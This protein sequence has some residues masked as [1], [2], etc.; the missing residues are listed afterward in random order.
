MA[1]GLVN[2]LFGD[3][4]EAYSAG[5]IPTIVHPYAVQVMAEVG[6]D[7]SQHKAKSVED[8]RDVTFD[9]VVTVCDNA[10]ETCPFFPGAQKYLHKGFADPAA[11]NG[12][13]TAALDTFRNVRNEIEAYIREII[14]KEQYGD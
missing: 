14:G 13:P 6:I 1:E 4:F 7:I 2:K 12:S 8:F 9:Y 5:V 10:R 11:F 3:T